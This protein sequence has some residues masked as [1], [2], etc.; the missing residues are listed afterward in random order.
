ARARSA[1]EGLR[2]SA[3]GIAD[4]PDPHARVRRPE[5]PAGVRALARQP[6]P[7]GERDAAPPVRARRRRPALRRGPGGHGGR[8]PTRCRRRLEGVRGDVRAAGQSA[9]PGRP[10]QPGPAALDRL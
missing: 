6:H 8:G 9:V 5:G 1:A 7:G 10:D 2:P 4:L 3:R